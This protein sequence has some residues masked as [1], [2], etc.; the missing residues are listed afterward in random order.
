MLHFARSQMGVHIDRYLAGSDLAPHAMNFYTI[1]AS[2]TFRANVNFIRRG[3]C[4]FVNGITVAQ[5]DAATDRAGLASRANRST[6]FFDG[7]IDI[8][9]AG[10]RYSD[11]AI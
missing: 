4:L 5:A 2:E 11:H 1:F 10:P 6:W 8:R 9:V 7:N 3:A